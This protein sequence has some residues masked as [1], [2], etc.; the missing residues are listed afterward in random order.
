MQQAIAHLVIRNPFGTMDVPSPDD[1]E[2]KDYAA[3]ATLAG[4]AADVNAAAWAAIAAP[5]DPIEGIWASRWNGGA[6]PTIAGDTPDK[7]KPGRAEIRIA[8]SRIYLRFDWDDG[9]RHGLI[10]AARDGAGRLVGKYINLTTPAI[11]RPWIGRVVEAGRIDGCFPE[12]R[13]DFRR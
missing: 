5:S 2:V 12:G 6:D 3:T 9:R 10:E 4:D 11:T 13:L 7:W 8:G 1:A